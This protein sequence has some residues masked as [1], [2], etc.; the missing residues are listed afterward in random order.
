MALCDDFS[1][2][3]RST[4]DVGV[5]PGR[6][7]SGTSQHGDCFH[8]PLQGALEKLDRYTPPNSAVNV[9]SSG[10][11]AFISR[12]TMAGKLF[13]LGLALLATAARARSLA[14]ASHRQG[15]RALDV[16]CALRGGAG[17]NNEE[18]TFAMLKPDVAKDDATVEAI[19]QKI[20]SAGLR[21]EREERARLSKAQCETFYQEH[22]ERPFFKTLVDFMSSGPVLKMELAGPNAIKV[23]RGLLGPT[24]TFKAQEEAPTSIRALFGTDGTQNAAHGSD[25]PES[26][27]RELEL[28][29]SS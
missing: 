7:L 3:K 13:V 9:S 28:M 10:D 22:S 23:W 29:F 1:G 8:C 15:V 19:K 4:R 5:A 17:R 26:A 24:N 14:V 2:A 21:I 12:D 20:E 25:A 18:R 6:S 16:V 11:F 27:S